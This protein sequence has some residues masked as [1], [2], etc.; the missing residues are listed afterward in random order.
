[1]AVKNFSKNLRLLC[2]YSRSISDLCERLSI[3]R[4]QFHRYLNGQSR[5]SHRNMLKICDHFGVEEHEIL[6]DAQDFRQLI[7]VR[8]PLEHEAD[9][10][11]EYIA[12]LYRINPDSLSE[13]LPFIGYY[14]CYYRPIEFQGK[15]QRSLMKVYRDRGYIYIKNVENYSSVKHR[16]RR[17]LKYTGIAFHTGE[18]IFVH[19]REM[20]AGQMIWTTILYPA[21]RDQT[22]VLTGLSLGI[23]SAATRDIACYHVV[24]E[25]LGQT[26]DLRQALKASG[27][28][29]EDD[30]AISD[31][32]REATLNVSRADNHGFV[33]RPWSHF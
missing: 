11:G 9:P 30:P 32:I 23:S 27:L 18:R 28:F 22:S 21:Q 14:H 26:I 5:P 24:W 13:M 2:S 17:T 20:N 1:M 6:M 25:P 29:N 31:E 19:E 7:A 3:N 15:I 4:Q 16:S 10:F 12:K 8:R 33:G